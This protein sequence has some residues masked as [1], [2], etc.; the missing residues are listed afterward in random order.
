MLDET[1]DALL[2]TQN[3][4]I[5]VFYVSGEPGLPVADILRVCLSAEFVALAGEFGILRILFGIVRY[6][7]RWS[8]FSTL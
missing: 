4:D 8:N 6:V 1:V 7:A 3:F 5:G 2:F